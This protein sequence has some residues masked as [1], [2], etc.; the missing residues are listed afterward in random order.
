[1]DREEKHGLLKRRENYNQSK[2]GGNK[3]KKYGQTGTG[4][5]VRIFYFAN[6]YI[7]VNNAR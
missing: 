4:Y 2:K 3:G 5:Y 7:L 6:V 1:M